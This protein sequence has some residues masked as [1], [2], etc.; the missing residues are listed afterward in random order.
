M[1]R[2]LLLFMFVLVLI[3]QSLD[4]QCYIGTENKSSVAKDPSESIKEV[5]IKQNDSREVYRDGIVDNFDNFTNP[6]FPT[7]HSRFHFHYRPPR[8]IEAYSS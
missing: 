4:M 2:I 3:V 1:R 8:I 6:G 7:E 5:K